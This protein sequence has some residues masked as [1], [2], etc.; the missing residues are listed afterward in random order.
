MSATTALAVVMA[1]W[2]AIGVVTAIAMDRRGHDA[3]TWMLLGAILGPLV[4]PLA[5][6]AQRR[7]GATTRPAGGGRAQESGRHARRRRRATVGDY[8][9][10]AAPHFPHPPVERLR[11]AAAPDPSASLAVCRG[12][13]RRRV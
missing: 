13:A 11:L 3:F 5:L 1:A 7:T 12:V 10:A 8:G 4:V 9:P 2:L 6:S